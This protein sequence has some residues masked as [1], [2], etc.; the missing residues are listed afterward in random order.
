M[1]VIGFVVPNQKN[2][3]LLAEQY[4]I[5]GSWEEL[6]D[7]AAMEEVVLQLIREVALSFERSKVIRPLREEREVID[8]W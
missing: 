4:L 6:C 7:N 8:R 1:Y 5:R 3:L 2:L